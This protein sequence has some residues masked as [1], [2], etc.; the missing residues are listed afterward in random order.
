MFAALS[1][2][3]EWC[4]GCWSERCER[5]GGV[6]VMSRSWVRVRQAAPTNCQFRRMFWDLFSVRKNGGVES[7][8]IP[9]VLLGSPRPPLRRSAACDLQAL[10]G[11]KVTNRLENQAQEHWL[12][13]AVIVASANVLYLR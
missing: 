11:Q 10:I 13:F 8:W 3:A 1:W 12:E 2:C 5:P 6:F 9:R 4:A 7:I